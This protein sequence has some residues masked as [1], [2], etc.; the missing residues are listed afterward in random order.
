[1]Q[2]QALLQTVLQAFQAGDLDHANAACNLYL[3]QTRTA[4]EQ[5]PARIW[6]GVIALKRDNAGLA[7]SH[8]E[9]AYPHAKQDPQLLQQM[10]L[11]H[12]RLGNSERAE[13]LYR[14]TIRA[15]PKF[16]AAHYNLGNL[17]QARREFVGARRAFEAAILHQPTL[18]VAHTNLANTLVALGEDSNAKTHYRQAIAIDANIAMPHHGLA[19]LLQKEQD[20]TGAETHYRRALSLSPLSFDVSLDL[21]DLLFATHRTDEAV[22]LVEDALASETISADLR[23]AAAFKRAQYRGESHNAMPQRMVEKLYAGM[24]GTF[25]DHLV[26]RLGYRVPQLLME[27]LADWFAALPAKPD[28]LDLG[29]GTGLFGPLVR[30]YAATL[31]G[32]DLSADMQSRA[33]ERG[34][35][36]TLVQQDV[37]TYLNESSA[38]FELIVATD[39]LIYIAPLPPLFA[40][41][42]ARLVPG[43]RFGFSTETPDDLREDFRLQ[44]SGRYAHSEKY[45]ERLAHEARLSII[46]K[47]PTIIRTEKN[48]P[49]KGYVFVV[50]SHEEK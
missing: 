26:G 34:A 20:V 33:R 50:Q 23:E 13:S 40:A 15:A 29:C 24:A 14:S 47:V 10:A 16:A 37:V 18:A 12:A 25:D 19:L 32:V 42:T 9:A 6:Q 27:R 2:P 4:H 44:P 30:P 49:V 3:Q 31:T 8:F 5:A 36:D 38:V 1:M 45:I 35:Y 48:L 11:A 41:V 17:L 39:V 7:L 46:E 28:V 21:A 22:A 43:G